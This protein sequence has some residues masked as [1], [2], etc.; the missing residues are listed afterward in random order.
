MALISLFSHR[1]GGAAVGSCHLVTQSQAQL[2]HIKHS[3]SPKKRGKAV[4]SF[5]AS[6][7]G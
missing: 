5:L 1:L 6:V 4:L 3:P 2:S 7:I